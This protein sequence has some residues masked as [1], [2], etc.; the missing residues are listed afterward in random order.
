M[1]TWWL[2]PSQAPSC[3]LP[4][5]CLL[6]SPH[7]PSGGPCQ[8]VGRG[9]LS[10]GICGLGACGGNWPCFLLTFPGEA[11]L[12]S[13]QAQVHAHTPG[14]PL[15]TPASDPKNPWQGLNPLHFLSWIHA[16]CSPPGRTMPSLPGLTTGRELV[17]HRGSV[18]TNPTGIHEDTDSIP[19]PAQ[20]VK[21][22]ALP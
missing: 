17:F 4:G 7:P 5:G 14:P 15:G 8:R 19:H 13:S 1:K 21:D 12:A 10:L 18:V 6:A 20:W 16:L 22:P 3:P 11:F 2:S 9:C